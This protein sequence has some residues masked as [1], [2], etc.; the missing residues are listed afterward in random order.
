MQRVP[1]EELALQVR[2]LDL[3]GIASVL[4]ETIDPPSPEAVLGAIS[5][6]RQIGALLVDVVTGEERLTELGHKLADMPIHPILGKLIFFGAIFGCLR[7]ILTIAASLGYKSPFY[8]PLGKEHRAD[9]AKRKLANGLSSDHMLLVRAYDEWSYRS[10]KDKVAFCN[11]YFLSPTAMQYIDKMRGEMEQVISVYKIDQFGV[12]LSEREWSDKGWNRMNRDQGRPASTEREQGVIEAVLCG[13]LRPC[14]I[15][16]GRFFPAQTKQRAHSLTSSSDD[17]RS[18][19]AA[20]NPGCMA[21]GHRELKK[22]H[23]WL[24]Y[25]TLQRTTQLF[26][27]DV[28]LV[29]SLS[30][31]LF[32]SQAAAAELPAALATNSSGKTDTNKPSVCSS[33]MIELNQGGSKHTYESRLRGPKICFSNFT[34]WS[35]TNLSVR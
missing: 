3:G 28:T 35:R 6:L 16:G 29:S 18:E 23:S 21:R 32:T 33:T 13:G 19:K 10:N 4:S 1:V 5:L 8:L 11:D 17:S 14:R 22:T 31:L 9:A 24:V 7:P 26:M 27:Y 12:E 2:D 20:L 15:E 30:M 25:F 34:H